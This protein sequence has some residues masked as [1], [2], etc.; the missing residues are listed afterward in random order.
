MPPAVLAEP[1][2]RLRILGVEVDALRVAEAVDRIA[3]LAADPASPA[4]YVVKPYVEFCD[5]AAGDPEV[6]SLLNGAELSL[7]DGVALQWAAGYQ[8]GAPGLR[9]LVGSLGAIVVR[10]SAVASVLPERFAGASFTT[11]LL[12]RCARDRLRVHLVGSPRAQTIGATAAHLK[13]LLPGLEISGASEGRDDPAGVD[14]LVAT[15][16]A[17]RPDIVLVGMGFPRQERLMARLCA[18]LDHAVLI[19]EG[20][21]FDYREFGGATRRAPVA[22]RRLG[23]EWLWRLALEPSRLRRQLAIPRFVWRVHRQARRAASRS[24]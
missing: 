21:T 12:E 10:P 4:V 15:L 5:R 7:P 17:E 13:R 24:S 11:A 19:G 16:R 23:L 9:R 1:P 20:G 2:P 3:T 8:A 6:A 18:R 14:G 22:L